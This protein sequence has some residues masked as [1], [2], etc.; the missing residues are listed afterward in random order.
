M[1]ILMISLWF[2]NG[3]SWSL[4]LP[5]LYCSQP[6]LINTLLFVACL[7]NGDDAKRGVSVR[8]KANL[9]RAQV[10]KAEHRHPHRI[11]RLLLG[12]PRVERFLGNPRAVERDDLIV[13]V[14]ALF[15]SRC[16]R[17][18]VRD[19]KPVASLLKIGAE[20]SLQ[21]NS[22]VELADITARLFQTQSDAGKRIAVSRRELIP[23]AHIAREK[24]IQIRARRQLAGSLHI[25]GC[26]VAALLVEVGVK[27]G[28]HV[29]ER[30]GAGRTSANTVLE[31]KSQQFAL[32]VI[33]NR[34]ID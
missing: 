8:A 32:A 27:I 26:V 5:V 13:C 1:L 22:S 21:R 23:P 7:S 28:H 12:N 2:H 20:K 34:R 17:A 10:V 18:H 16:A 15:V 4:P 6:R 9:E 25:L 24:L 11:A 30:F 14:Q 19:Q 29:I 31:Q 33:R 3:L